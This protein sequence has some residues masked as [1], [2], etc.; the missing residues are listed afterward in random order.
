MVNILRLL[1]QIDT[2]AAILFCRC[3]LKAG[4]EIVNERA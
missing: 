4:V 1:G 3:A 2:V